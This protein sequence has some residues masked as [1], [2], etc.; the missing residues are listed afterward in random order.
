MKVKRSPDALPS[1]GVENEPK[2][3]IKKQAIEEGKQERENRKI[4]VSEGIVEHN[5]PFLVSPHNIIAGRVDSDRNSSSQV[6]NRVEHTA[7]FLVNNFTQGFAN[8]CGVFK[9]PF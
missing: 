7:Y 3:P 9:I 4:T 1:C 8:E 5:L 6:Y 2:H